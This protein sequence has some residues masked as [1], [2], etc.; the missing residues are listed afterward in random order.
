[1]KPNLPTVQRIAM[2]DAESV[3][4]ALHKATTDSDTDEEAFTTIFL[5]SKKSGNYTVIPRKTIL[6]EILLETS[7]RCFF[8]L[9]R[10]KETR[11]RW[12]V[13][14][15]LN[16]RLHLFE[17]GATK[18]E[19]DEKVFYSILTI[20]GWGQLRHTI[21]EYETMHGLSLE[22]AVTSESSANARRGI[23]ELLERVQNRPGDLAERLY[24]A[25]KRLGTSE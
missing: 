12:P 21:A 11:R 22:N 10:F 19:T 4:D 5:P 6:N 17:A 23:L 13:W 7:T 14:R 15:K 1:M 20:L 8:H 24:N 9:F 16:R 3:A 25:L 2:F 18:L